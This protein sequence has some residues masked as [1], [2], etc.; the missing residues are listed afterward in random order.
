MEEKLPFAGVS[1]NLK[2]KMCKSWWVASKVDQTK[3]IELKMPLVAKS[4]KEARE[5]ELKM[6]S[7]LRN[8]EL[9]FED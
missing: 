7:I 9:V 1:C 2:E 3:T 6:E 4:E 8:S 5:F